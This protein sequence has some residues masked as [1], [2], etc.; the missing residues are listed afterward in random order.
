M[1]ADAHRDRLRRTFDTAAE[2]YER[3]RPTYPDALFDRLGTVSGIAAGDRLL[4]VGCGTGQATRALLRRGFRVTCVE[5]GGQ[6]AAVARRELAGLGEVEVVECDF[7]ALPPHHSGYDLVLSATAWHWIDP[8][9]RYR[10]AWE[11]VRPG[12]HLALWTA[13]HVFPRDGDPIFVE[14]QDTYDEIGE[15]LPDDHVLPRPGELP[16][17]RDEIERSGCFDVVDVSQFD[18]ETVHDADSYIAL[19][20]T[21]SGHIAM[22]PWKRDRL[23][24]EIRARLGRRADGRLRRHWGAVLHVARRRD[25]T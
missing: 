6:L 25:L 11:V 23:F 13:T 2:R 12:G 8:D 17:A 4:E 1:A 18:W 10:R 3:S 24:G 16:D 19:L 21:F 14:L 7:E 5:P 9:L 22:E 20:E 15:R